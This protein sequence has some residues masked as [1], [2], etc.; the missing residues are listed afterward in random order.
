MSIRY[1][2]VV[3][4]YNEEENI[5]LLYQRIT[6]VMGKLDGLSELVLVNDGSY[7]KSLGIIKELRQQDPRVCYLNFS[8]NFGHQIAVTAGLNFARGDA[9]IVLD[10]DL[11]DPPEL[12]SEMI[13][14]WH[15]GYQVVYAQRTQRL[16]ESILKRFTAY[17]FYR[18]L[19]FLSDFDI[20]TDTGDFCLLDRSVVNA[21]NSLPERNRYLRGLRAWVGFS[22]TAI[23]FKRHPRNG[24][25]VKYT[26]QKSLALAI[27]GLVSFSKV[28]L[29]ISTYLG[30]V[31]AAMAIAM[32]F[33]VI[34]WRFFIPNSPLTG[35]A[36]IVCAIFFLGAVQL[37][38]IGILGEYIGR[39]YEE[40][41][42]RPSYILKEVAGF[43][44]MPNS[45]SIFNHNI[46]AEDFAKH[47]S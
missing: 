16:Q 27:N 41:K 19:K 42:N 47:R 5:D 26:F 46:H 2:F 25:D 44:G 3:P 32:A 39:I 22:Q 38:S 12:S 23:Q 20:P 33:L 9:I 35:I 7:D 8:R 34:Y 43:E 37:I 18:I 36:A 6:A 31:S 15:Q 21:L 10:A 13:A 24:G 29:R 1:S 28:P 40:V 45:T 4:I 17:I 14:L 30:I 11:Q